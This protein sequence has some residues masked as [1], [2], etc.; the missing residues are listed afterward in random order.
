MK[1][2]ASDHPS[3]PTEGL[4][5]LCQGANEITVPA[6]FPV[7]AVGLWLA[8]TPRG[9]L[10]RKMQSPR[11]KF[12]SRAPRHA[13]CGHADRSSS[14]NGCENGLLAGAETRRQDGCDGE[15]VLRLTAHLQGYHSVWL[16]K[17]A[18][19]EESSLKKR[20]GKQHSKTAHDCMECIRNLLQGTRTTGTHGEQ[21]LK[22][23]AVVCSLPPRS[24][25]RRDAGEEA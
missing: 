23:V 24:D 6:V 13:L 10:D 21:Q 14:C 3:K 16:V 11:G 7:T 12:F 5:F 18:A 20:T 19:A 1:K 15:L 17:R 9:P 25:N 4:T 8:V 2:E 22:A